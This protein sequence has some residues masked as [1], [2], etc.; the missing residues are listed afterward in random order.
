MVLASGSVPTMTERALDERAARTPKPPARASRA[1]AE[2]TSSQRVY[3]AAW[4][5]T[6]QGLPFYVAENGT[7]QPADFALVVVASV[8]GL[9]GIAHVLEYRRRVLSSLG[10]LLA[11]ICMVNVA[12]A[13][14]LGAPD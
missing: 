6:L 7:P 11:I 2:P 14:A 5:C 9:L 8:P 13:A 4:W 3:L 1:T 10:V 12:W